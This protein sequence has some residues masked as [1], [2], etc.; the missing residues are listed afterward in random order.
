M[1]KFHGKNSENL[2]KARQ[3]ISRIFAEKQPVTK[4]ENNAQFS[5]FQM[6]HKNPICVCAF[7]LFILQKKYGKS[8][9]MQVI[10]G[11]EQKFPSQKNIV[12]IGTFDGLHH[13]HKKILARLRDIQ[14]QNPDYTTVV[15]TFHPH[16]RSVVGGEEVKILSTIEEKTKLIADEGID[17]LLL[18]PFDRKFSEMTPEEFTQK[19][20]CDFL[21]TKFLII[22]YDHKFGK[23]RSGNYEFLKS[24]EERFGFKVMEITK[25]QIEDVAVSSTKIRQALLAGN[26]K[27]ANEY[28]ERPYSLRGKVVRGNQIGRTL[29]FPTA[30]IETGNPQKLVPADGIYAVNVEVR[31]QLYGGVLSVGVRPTIGQNLQRT[32]EVNIFDFNEDIYDEEVCL[33]FRAFIRP[34]LKFDSLDVLV[35]QMHEDKRNAE[36]ILGEI[37]V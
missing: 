23:N 31:G 3:V 27:T 22:G 4:F 9:A 11:T 13:G 1:L 28:L 7:L 6:S 21:H 33:F 32:V 24:G 15:M 16:P 25:Q 2:S 34:E 26:I 5:S 36:R 18:L 29:G 17:F 20:L 12:T 14:A 19:V 10:V 30:N 35:A 8:S 37:S